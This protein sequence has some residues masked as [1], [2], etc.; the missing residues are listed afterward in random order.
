MYCSV[1]TVK[2]LFKVRKMMKTSVNPDHGDNDGNTKEIVHNLRKFHPITG[3]DKEILKRC[4]SEWR[5]NSRQRVLA[6]SLVST[7][8]IFRNNPI[9]TF[10]F[11][12]RIYQ[13]F[14][15]SPSKYFTNYCWRNGVCNQAA[16]N[17]HLKSNED[18]FSAFIRLPVN[19]MNAFKKGV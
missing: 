12:S 16:I 15:A 14:N 9:R 4:Y 2:D 1:R 18:L 8:T 13:T 17:K 7:R 5:V 11:P 6:R 19:Q 10:L 3:E